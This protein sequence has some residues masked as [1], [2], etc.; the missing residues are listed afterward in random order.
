[1]SAQHHIPDRY[2][3]TI[4]MV[5]PLVVSVVLCSTKI[6]VSSNMHLSTAAIISRSVTVSTAAMST[7][8][9][10]MKARTM[11]CSRRQRHRLSCALVPRRSISLR[12]GR[13][14][15]SRAMAGA[16]LFKV[17]TTVHLDSTGD[18]R[19]GCSSAAWRPTLSGITGGVMCRGDVWISSVERYRCWWSRF[20]RSSSRV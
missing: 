13:H 14:V 4:L 9:R 2:V 20:A 6:V 1:M 18:T 15:N 3:R 7:V 5:L 12:W 19:C 11:F 10:L 8:S 17:A 16:K